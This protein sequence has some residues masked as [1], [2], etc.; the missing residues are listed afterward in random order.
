[1]K[2]IKTATTKELTLKD[3]FAVGDKI[4]VTSTFFDGRGYENYTHKL[5]VVKVNRVTVDAKDKKD[6]IYRL[7]LD[8]LQCTTK[9]IQEEVL[10]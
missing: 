1:M 9:V 7:D 8:D 10:A 6:N 3:R 5:E 4:K 2:L